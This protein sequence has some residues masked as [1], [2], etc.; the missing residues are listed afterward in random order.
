MAL[1]NASTTTFVSCWDSK[2]VSV[3]LSTKH[4][5]VVHLPV[6]P[7]EYPWVGGVCR[8]VGDPVCPVLRQAVLL[9]HSTKTAAYH[10]H[11]GEAL[12]TGGHWKIVMGKSEILTS[13]WMVKSIG[14]PT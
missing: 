10:S 11:L 14:G 12:V 4:T 2:I 3:Y 5:S 7:A 13:S 6:Y 9:R 8:P 1:G